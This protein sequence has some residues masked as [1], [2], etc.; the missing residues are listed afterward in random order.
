ME[1]HQPLH[2]QGHSTVQERVNRARARFGAPKETLPSRFRE[3]EK[4]TERNAD[5]GDKGLWEDWSDKR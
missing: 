1:R 3:I 5:W 4:V 2:N